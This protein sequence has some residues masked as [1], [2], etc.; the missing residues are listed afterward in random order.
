MTDD[1]GMSWEQLLGDI[2]C[3]WSPSEFAQLCVLPSCVLIPQ[4]AGMPPSNGAWD[5]RWGQWIG[6][7]GVPLDDLSND[8]TLTRLPPSVPPQRLALSALSDSH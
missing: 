6:R 1:I 4:P 2:P 5:M 3:I 7:D 8:S